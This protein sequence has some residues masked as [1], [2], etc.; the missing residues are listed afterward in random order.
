MLSLLLDS[1]LAGFICSASIAVFTYVVASLKKDII[2]VICANFFVILGILFNA[3]VIFRHVYDDYNMPNLYH[4]NDNFYFNQPLL[5]TH[6]A[7]PE[8][9]SVYLTNYQGFR[10]GNILDQ[11]KSVDSCDVLFVGDSFTQ[12]AQ[13]DY[14]QMYS[15]LY[16]EKVS[17]IKVV[18]AG[19]SGANVIDEFYFISKIGVHLQPKVIVLQLCMNNDFFDVV[20][21]KSGINEWLKEKSALYR[22]A[23][24]IFPSNYK[25]KI[26]RCVDPFFADEIANENYNIFY[27]KSS[28]I[29]EK[30]KEMLIYAI[31]RI[32]TMAT[33]I[34]AELT[35]LIIPSKEQISNECFAEVV[36]T[37][38]LDTNYID[39]DYPNSWLSTKMDSLQIGYIDV[40]DEFRK[41]SLP[42]YFKNDIHLTKYGHAVVA[43]QLYEYFQR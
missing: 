21:H 3:E 8:F 9:N 20:E 12:G 15:S 41:Q 18:N 19:I 7:D 40:T 39:L 11:Y 14:T 1:L 25:S 2:K 5:N 31:D 30:D 6:F 36:N 16:E 13:V 22:S 43:N 23:S 37:Y 24:I 4:A 28:S 35:V 34:G 42:M 17:K 26:R 27:T 38:Q 33:Q 29:K 32:N 10:V